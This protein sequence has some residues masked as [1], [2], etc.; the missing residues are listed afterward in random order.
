MK[1]DK[2]LL[3]RA[4]LI[5]LREEARSMAETPHMNPDWVHAYQDLAAAADKL[6][7]MQA[8]TE[9]AIPED[10]APD[11]ADWWKNDR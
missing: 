11:P 8:R 1:L 6:D 7:A 4:F 10:A 5:D 3:E 9:L 2:A